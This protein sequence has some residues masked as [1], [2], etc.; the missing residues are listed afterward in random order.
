MQPPSSSILFASL[1][2]VA[3]Q[4]SSPPD[5]A[6]VAH[7]AVEDVTP[8]GKRPM[9]PSDRLCQD[10]VTYVVADNPRLPVVRYADGQVSLSDSC[11]VRVGSRLNRKVPPAYING[12]PLGFC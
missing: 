7:A 11:A 4:T 6:A 8:P 2:I 3:C 9:H 5:E 10:G 12:Q 1:L